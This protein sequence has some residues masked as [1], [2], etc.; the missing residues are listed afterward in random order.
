MSYNDVLTEVM[1]LC[2]QAIVS[3]GDAVK[4]IALGDIADVVSRVIRGTSAATEDEIHEAATEEPTTV[5]CPSLVPLRMIAHDEPAAEVPRQHGAKIANGVRLFRF[6]GGDVVKLVGCNQA[7]D[8][9]Q[10]HVYEIEVKQAGF[11]PKEFVADC[12]ID[13][14]NVLQ[15][16]CT[17]RSRLEKIAV[18]A[19][20]YYLLTNKKPGQRRAIKR[21]AENKEPVNG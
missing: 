16:F 7:E 9:K 20:R 21:R 13:G 10:R 14:A 1:H 3:N 8:L 6:R 5:G 15:L 17:S 4:R 12:F 18:K 19:F 2:S 11:D